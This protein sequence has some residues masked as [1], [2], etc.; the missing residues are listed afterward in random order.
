VTAL[1]DDRQQRIIEWLSEEHQDLASLYE[2]A[3]F[4]LNNSL[5]T[6]NERTRLSLICHSMRELVNRLPDAFGIPS[7]DGARSDYSNQYQ[8]LSD[9]AVKYP[10]LDLLASIE[11]VPVPQELAVALEN[12]IANSKVANIRR[13]DQ[14]AAMLTEDQNSRHPVVKEWKKL[15]QFFVEW[16]HLSRAQS[17]IANLPTED[18]LRSQI[19]SVE[20]IIYGIVAPFF[21]NR[22]LIDEILKNANLETSAKPNG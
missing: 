21:D 18:E 6:G 13:V 12:L 1:L 14:L 15:S 5:M 19:R 2:S 9:I 10:N 16:A 7:P 3:L 4:F 8:L 20:E 11:Y 22:H 17:L